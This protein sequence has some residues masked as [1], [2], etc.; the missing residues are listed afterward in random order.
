MD[1]HLFQ[2]LLKKIN[3][4]NKNVKNKFKNIMILNN[5]FIIILNNF[6]II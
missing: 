6:L 2:F 3:A 4:Y 1:K 5:I